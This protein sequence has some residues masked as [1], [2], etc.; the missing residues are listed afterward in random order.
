VRTLGDYVSCVKG[1]RKDKFP[2]GGRV[3]R[4]R[5]G[6]RLFETW[7]RQSNGLVA[8]C[9]YMSLETEGVEANDE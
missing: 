7:I 8:Y 2:T 1:V 4:S 9:L 3:I 5:V 6:E